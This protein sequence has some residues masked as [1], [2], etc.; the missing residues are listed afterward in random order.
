MK[1]IKFLLILYFLNILSISHSQDIISLVVINNE[2]IT[3]YDLNLE[4]KRKKILEKKEIN[5]TEAKETLQQLIDEKIKFLEVEKKDITINNNA[6]KSR[7][8]EIIEKNNLQNI[9]QELKLYI[10]NKISL[11]L[12]WNKLINNKF[13]RQIEININEVNEIMKSRNIDQKNFDK[14][15]NQEKNKK[16]NIFS[17]I[18]LNEIKKEFLIKRFI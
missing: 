8:N 6:I 7:L 16:L 10:Q 4:L 5:E 11:N 12:R 18:Y 17:K 1:L 9:N 14:I 13:Q 15:V 2:I 3:N